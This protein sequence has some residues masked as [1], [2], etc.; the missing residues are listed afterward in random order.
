MLPATTFHP[1]VAPV[2]EDEMEEVV[3]DASH[4]DDHLEPQNDVLA[5][6]S[7]V[8]SA[9]NILVTLE[10]SSN[11]ELTFEDGPTVLS[12]PTSRLPVSTDGSA[13]PVPMSVDSSG[14]PSTAVD[15]QNG[16]KR[17]KTGRH[18]PFGFWDYMIL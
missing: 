14:L 10:S 13:D 1:D 17:F 15:G 2:S 12:E 18:V 16:G 6:Q 3:V 4:V 9:D 5:S 11:D 7:Y 8:D